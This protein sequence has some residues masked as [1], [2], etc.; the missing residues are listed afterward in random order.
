MAKMKMFGVSPPTAKDVGIDPAEDAAKDLLEA[1][2]DKDPKAIAA[3]F[4]LLMACC[5]EEPDEDDE[6]DDDEDD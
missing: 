4:K 6:A 2:D 5:E 3:A 1:I